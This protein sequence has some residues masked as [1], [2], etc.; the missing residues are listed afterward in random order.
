MRSAVQ[1]GR[2]VVVFKRSAVNFAGVRYSFS[3]V[4]LKVLPQ[5]NIL[6]VLSSSRSSPNSIL[7]YYCLLRGLPSIQ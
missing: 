6:L 2:Q 3:V 1:T 4:F 5:F 7:Y